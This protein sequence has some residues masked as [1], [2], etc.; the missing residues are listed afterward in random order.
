MLEAHKPTG[1]V[2]YALTTSVHITTSVFEDNSANRGGVIALEGNSDIIIAMSKF[3]RNHAISG[4]AIAIHMDE[5]LEVEETDGNIFIASSSFS[6]N[7]AR[8]GGG[9]IHANTLQGSVTL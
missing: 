8:E 5:D 1:G 7:T 3:S 2:L 9:G 4:G 6:D